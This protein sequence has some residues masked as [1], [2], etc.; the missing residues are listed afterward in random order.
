MHCPWLAS[1]R[2]LDSPLI[3]ERPRVRAWLDRIAARP[4]VQRGMAVPAA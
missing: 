3:A 4:A 2:A 1:M